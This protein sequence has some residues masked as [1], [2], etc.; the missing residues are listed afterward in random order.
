MPTSSS[1][2]QAGGRRPKAIMTLIERRPDTSNRL[3]QQTEVSA[4][5]QISALRILTGKARTPC[6]EEQAE[7]RGAFPLL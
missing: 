7:H 4:F 5:E 6:V 3:L 2:L 1:V